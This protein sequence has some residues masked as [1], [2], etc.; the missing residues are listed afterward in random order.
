MTGSQID[1]LLKTMAL[2]GTLL[3]IGTFLRAKVSL[4]QN[5]FLPACVIGGIIGLILGPIVAVVL[6]ALFHARKQ[7]RELQ[8]PL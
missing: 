7:N 4:F 2:V 6:K 5:L 3:L 8:K 1:V